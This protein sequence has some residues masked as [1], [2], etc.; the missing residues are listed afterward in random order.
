MSR[1]HFEDPPEHDPGR[2]YDNQQNQDR[3]QILR[4]LRATAPGRWA[5]VSYHRS[6][7]RSAQVARE[8]RGRHPDF[9]FRSGRSPQWGEVVYGRHMAA[10]VKLE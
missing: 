1:I 9:E 3:E 6:R 7:A 8:L 10:N 5:I 2:R 4:A